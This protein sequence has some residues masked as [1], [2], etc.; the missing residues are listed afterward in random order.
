MTGKMYGVA[1]LGEK[2]ES[3]TSLT[4]GAVIATGPYR[5]YGKVVIVQMAGGY[6]Y[7]YCGCESLSVKMGDQVA[8]GTEL[9]RLGIDGATAKPQLFLMVYRNSTP[10]DP[11]KAPR[12]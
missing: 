4:R 7:V 8:P 1:L 5:G 6:F 11:A 10:L 3:V 2:S 12:A 9:G